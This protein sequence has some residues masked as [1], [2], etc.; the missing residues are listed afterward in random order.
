ADSD[1]VAV[2]P[3]C[4]ELDFELEVAAIVG[5]AGRDLDAGAATKHIAGFTIMNDWS[6]RDIQRREMKL[7][8]GPAKG[9]DFATNFGPYFVTPDE[10]GDAV[11][12]KAYD[13]AMTARVN[14][15]E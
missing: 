7:N 5:R 1:D 9:K 8:P 14:G 12:G 10:L 15:R 3:G 2:P 6:A 11:S 4:A 13:L